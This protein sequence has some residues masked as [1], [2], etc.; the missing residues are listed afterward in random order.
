M[1]ESGYYPPGA[2]HDPRAPWNEKEPN[3]V[4]C[5]ACNGKGCHWY[6]Y[7]IETNEETECTEEAW[8]CLPE[9]EEAAEAKHQHYI[10]GEKETC[11]ACDGV[12]EV[13]YEADYEPDYD[14]YYER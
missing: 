1:Y 7:N 8:C 11:E 10:R 5:E 3:M 13:E 9:T 12:G 4:K 6:A 2:E 14:D